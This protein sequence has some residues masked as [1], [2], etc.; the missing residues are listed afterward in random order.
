MPKQRI[1]RQVRNPLTLIAVFAGL[2]EV[3]ATGVLPVIEGP[4]QLTFVWYVMLFPV[5]L[6]IAFFLTLNF[7]HRVLYAPSDYHDE[8]HFLATSTATYSSETPETE[9]LRKFWKPKGSINRSNENRLKEWLKANGLAPDSITFFLR[10]E[11]F[12]D[13]RRRAVTDL[14][15]VS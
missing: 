6:V 3:A 15:L 4:V 10:N 8:R 5:L 7:N 9:S 12:A 2:A 14:R 11:L 1:P 13:A